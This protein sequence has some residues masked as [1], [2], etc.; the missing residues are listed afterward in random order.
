M[1]LK[2]G[3]GR[4]GLQDLRGISGSKADRMLTRLM[5]SKHGAGPDALLG[6][7]RQRGRLAYID[8]FQRANQANDTHQSVDSVEFGPQKHAAADSRLSGRAC[9]GMLS[10]E[11]GRTVRLRH[12]LRKVR[13]LVRGFRLHSRRVT[14]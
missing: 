9:I 6:G 3:F 12:G 1:S 7:A 13:V 8:V 10:M 14:G 11:F 2:S 5:F 4:D